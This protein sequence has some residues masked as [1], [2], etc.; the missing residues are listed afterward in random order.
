MTSSDIFNKYMLNEALYAYTT[1]QNDILWNI[2]LS[3]LK[4]DLP[5]REKASLYMIVNG[6]FE[7]LC[8]EKI[9][10]NGVIDKLVTVLW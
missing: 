4:S 3:S 7:K 8:K 1:E 6:S 2:L 9:A 10:P 5:E